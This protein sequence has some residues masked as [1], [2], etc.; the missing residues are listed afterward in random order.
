MTGA[1]RA[2]IELLECPMYGE[3]MRL[4]QLAPSFAGIPELRTFQCDECKFTMTM[5]HHEDELPRGPLQIATSLILR[6]G[7]S[8]RANSIN[9]TASL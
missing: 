7:R 1:P 5:A 4:S 9:Y 2:R 3:P 8:S 6:R